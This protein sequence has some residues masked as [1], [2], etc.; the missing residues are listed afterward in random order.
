MNADEMIRGNS[1]EFDVKCNGKMM[2]FKSEISIIMDQSIFV[3]GIKVNNQTV[4]FSDKC[5]INFLYKIDGKLYL[6]EN[7]NVKLVKYNGEIYHKVDLTGDGKSYNRRDSYR[8][9]LGEDMS[10]YINSASGPTSLSVLV[11]DISETGVGFIT[12]EDL[13]IDRSFR[14]RL[15]DNNM[16]IT[17]SGVIVRKELIEHLNKTLYGCK[18]S[19]KNNLLIKYIARRQGEQLRSKSKSYSSPA[20]RDV[21]IHN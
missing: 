21:M 20:K 11:K 7:V 8:L 5:S 4:G 6:W 9:Y 16:I 14:L 3:T 12:A 2:N 19:E 15:K 1:V 18:F 13:D 17:L 10:I